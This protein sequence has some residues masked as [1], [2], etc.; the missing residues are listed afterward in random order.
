MTV[1]EIKNEDPVEQNMLLLYSFSRL[2]NSG[3]NPLIPSLLN[4]LIPLHLAAGFTEGTLCC[5]V[6]FFAVL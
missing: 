1:S 5:D 6:S 3:A 4:G 2:I